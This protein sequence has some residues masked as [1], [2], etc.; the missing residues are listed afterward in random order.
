ECIVLVDALNR[1]LALFMRNT[2]FM[3]F[4]RRYST[5]LFYEKPVSVLIDKENTPLILNMYTSPEQVIQAALKRDLQT[6]YDCVII[7]SGENILQ[8]VLTLS[9]ILELSNELQKHAKYEQAALIEKAVGYVHHIADQMKLVETEIV[10][11]QQNFNSMIDFTL[12]GKNLLESIMSS[13]EHIIKNTN[14]QN[15]QINNMKNDSN[16]LRKIAHS[17]VELSEQSNLLALNA[18]IEAAKAKEHGLAFNVVATE[19]R[20]LAQKTKG[21]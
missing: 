15:E 20:N 11:Q 7:V 1:P 3:K 19:V 9:N 16:Q 14:L 8:G 6:R 18:T 13:F 10:N 21:S 17:V 2:L 4:S 5:D 12:S